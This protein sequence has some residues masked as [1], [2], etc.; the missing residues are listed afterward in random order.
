MRCVDGKIGTACI[1]EKNGEYEVILFSPYFEPIRREYSSDD[2]IVNIAEF[3]LYLL[4]HSVE[5]R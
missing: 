4:L 2:G 3:E 1:Q 5:R